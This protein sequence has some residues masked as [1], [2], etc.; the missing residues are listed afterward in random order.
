MLNPLLTFSNDMEHCVGN[1]CCA[2]EY[3]HPTL[4]TEVMLQHKT[5]I[6]MKKHL[7]KNVSQFLDMTEADFQ[8]LITLKAASAAGFLGYYSL[9]SQVRYLQHEHTM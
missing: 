2:E 4:C 6:K 1:Q 9:N 8:F 7:W 3:L 5:W